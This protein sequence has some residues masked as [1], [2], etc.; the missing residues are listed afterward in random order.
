[1]MKF[2][3]GLSAALIGVVGIT[4][5]NLANSLVQSPIALASDADPSIVVTAIAKQITVRI[6]GPSPDGSSNGSGVI[7][8]KKGNTYTVLTNYHVVQTPGDYQIQTSDGQRYTV[9][10]SQMLQVPEVDLAVLKFTSNQNYR[11]VDI[12][13]EPVR[14]GQTIYVA[15]WPNEGQQINQRIF[16]APKGSIQNRLTE[17][18]DGYALVYT[19]EVAK[20]GMSGGPVLDERG[21]ILG[22]NGRA[23]I[24]LRPNSTAGLVLGIPID[25]YDKWVA[26]SNPTSSPNEIQSP[27]PSRLVQPVVT[28]P[29]PLP[30]PVAAAPY[31]P[32][33]QPSPPPV[34]AAPSQIPLPTYIVLSNP[35][36]NQSISNSEIIARVDSILARFGLQPTACTVEPRVEIVGVQYTAC[37]YPTSNYP[38]GRYG[39]TR[40]PI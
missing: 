5:L 3:C 14:S 4:S 30:A 28:A 38:A 31:S 7:I 29:Q 11:V 12:N 1:M 35:Q 21:R 2:A 8:D 6:D 18:K 16:I 27:S 37:A 15:G 26:A 9:N 20:G 39:I 36:S 17:A 19:L 23:E 10:A 32:P 34:A 22:I 33:P 24:D 13:R 40:G 25:Q